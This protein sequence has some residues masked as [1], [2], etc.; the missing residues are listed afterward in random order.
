M[1]LTVGGT[2]GDEDGE[3]DGIGVGYKVGLGTNSGYSILNV[4]TTYMTTKLYFFI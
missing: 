2:L 4:L 1:G 3:L